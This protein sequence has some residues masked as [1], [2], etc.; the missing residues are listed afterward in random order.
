MKFSLKIYAWDIECSVIACYFLM[1]K[2]LDNFS[3]PD[4]PIENSNSKSVLEI[5][6]LE[7]FNALNATDRSFCRM[8]LAL[9]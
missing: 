3:A 8:V 9:I 6:G 5:I 7:K 1:F 4:R 2:M